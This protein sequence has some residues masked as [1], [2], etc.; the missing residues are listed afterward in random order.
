MPI[1]QLGRTDSNLFHKFLVLCK[2]NQAERRS[3]EIN[4]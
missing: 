2:K 4:Y 3:H 1:N